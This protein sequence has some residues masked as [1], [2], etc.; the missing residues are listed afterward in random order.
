[1]KTSTNKSVGSGGY[2]TFDFMAKSKGNTVIILTYNKPWE[3]LYALL[4]PDKFNL[5]STSLLFKIYYN[6][7]NSTTTL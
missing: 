3:D 1:M 6:R 5:S 7:N 2:E 4:S